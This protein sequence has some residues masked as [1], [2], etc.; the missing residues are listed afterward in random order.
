MKRKQAF[1]PVFALALGAVVLAS[2]ALFLF[3]YQ[4]DNKYTAPRPVS[5]QGVTR[6][7]MAWY[8]SH[9]FFYLVDGWE[10]YRGTLSPGE[11]EDARPDALLYLGRYGGFDLGD[12]KANPFGAAT[13]RTVLMFDGTE[14]D[15]ALE[16]T[17]I[18]SRWRLWVNGELVQSVGMGDEDAP[19]PQ[20]TQ[21]VFSVSGSVELVVQVWDD[22]HFYSGM[23]YPP[24]FGSPR[25]VGRVSDL[26]LLLHAGAC[27][28][29]LLIAVLCVPVGVR[30]HFRRPYLALALLCLCF[31]GSA[32][33]PLFQSLGWRGEAWPL[34]E[35]V[36]NY[37][38]FLSL[39]AIQGRVCGIPKRVFW[40]ACGVGIAV[41]ASVALQPLIPVSTAQPLMLY[42][43]LLGAYKWLAAAWLLGTSLWALNREISYS[44]P[45]LAGSC[46]FSCALVMDKLLPLHEPILLGWFVEL[47]G[48]ILIF[49]IAGIA[50]YDT[51][52]VYRE[53]VDLRQQKALQEVRL[54]AWDKQARLQ[55]EYV[56][57]T[58]AQLHE[59]RH[60]LTLI[61]HYLEAGETDKL[62]DYLE[63]LTPRILEG[64]PAEY[65]G[66]NLADAILGAQFALA[67]QHGIY[68]EYDCARLPETL[69]VSDDDLTSALMNLLD[70]AV[71]GCNRLSDPGERWLFFRISRPE[72]GLRLECRNSALPGAAERTSKRDSEAHGFGL[73]IL[74]GLARR[75]HGGLELH[76]GEDA[77]EAV[78]TFLEP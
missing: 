71:E 54:E 56:R 5:E 18:Y 73:S 58:R 49:L 60:R 59:S 55:R 17:Q 19:A 44:K 66:N 22:N 3:C 15:Y 69:F 43:G 31:C 72:D 32:A 20:D 67:E 40:P 74:R 29:A 35:R 61:R 33:W 8:E 65:T 63:E 4:Y 51:V 47:A 13:Y 64:A 7:D 46:L 1:S 37:G 75:Y 36:C 24:A 21:A 34:L 23:V 2:C 45:L 52:R 25:A 41:C 6:V 11:F 77:F 50:W 16:L 10:F 57:R 70:N 76:P 38:I 27:A 39:L 30:D 26:R 28:L 48:G 62:S 9:P 53:S 78:L 12:P 68:V 14:R 42:A